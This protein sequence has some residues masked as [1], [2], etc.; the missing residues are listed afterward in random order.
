MVA[1]PRLDRDGQALSF[2]AANKRV[3]LRRPLNNDF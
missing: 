2:S 1:A 3:R